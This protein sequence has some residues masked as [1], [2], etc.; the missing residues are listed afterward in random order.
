MR[1]IVIIGGGNAGLSCAARVLRQQPR[2]SVRVTVVEPSPTHTY[3]PMLSYVGS[4]MAGLAQVCRAQRRYVPAGAEW[5][6]RSVTLVRPEAHTVVLDDGSELDYDDL[7]VAPGIMPDHEQIPGLAQALDT[8]WAATNYDTQL[9][10]KTW[11]LMSGLRSGTAVF[12]VRFHDVACGGVGYKPLFTACDYWRR[13]GVLQ[14]LRV[15]AIVEAPEFFPEPKVAG[16]IARAMRRYGITAITG[17]RVE[18]VDPAVRGITF[19]RGGAP[20]SLAYDALHVLPPHR[21]PEWIARS[22]LAGADPMGRVDV[23]PETL[24]HRRHPTVWSLGDAATLDTMS[25]GGAIRS[26]S[27]V[28][29]HNIFEPDPARFQRYDG[30]TVAPITLSRRSLVLAEVDRRHCPEPSFGI[31][32]LAN[33]RPWTFA[34]DRFLQPV[35]YW[36]GILRGLI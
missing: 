24:Q 7:V 2:G 30:Y 5:L 3:S 21:A 31:R 8:P 35:L 27:P 29:V 10:P 11:D 12:T 16:H 14:D 33:P 4:G 1:S 34:F 18:S 20:E 32:D 22:G 23:D 25:S 17:A 28:L 36:Q 6:R 9:A 15:Y 13:T 26:Q 19:S